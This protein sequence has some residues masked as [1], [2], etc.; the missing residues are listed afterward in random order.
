MK[1][2]TCFAGIMIFGLVAMGICR[3]QNSAQSDS[4]TRPASV[5]KPDSLD[6]AGD[7]SQHK[8][9]EFGPVLNG[10]N[11]LYDRS[12]Y[13]FFWAGAQAGKILTPMIHAGPFS[14][15]FEF[16][17]EVFPVWQAY[18]PA[19]YSQTVMVNGQPVVQ[20]WGG[21]NF[22]G[23]AVMPVIFRWNFAT[24]TRRFVPWFQAA[25][26]V[27]YTTHKFPPNLL[28]P[29][30]TPGGTSV[31]NFMPQGGVG[32]HYFLRSRRSIDVGLNAVHISSASL[33]DKNPGVNSSLQLQ[34]GYTWWK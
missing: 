3:A 9:W 15:Q 18:T 17:A 8:R 30:G 12:S 16:G 20:N 28:V 34:V 26:G 22:Y 4:S 21:G 6:W 10:G 23:V 29:H 19:P 25:G 1:K 13:H 24:P 7:V 2:Y 14:G 33:G 32:F 31:F 11:G 27:I 5:A